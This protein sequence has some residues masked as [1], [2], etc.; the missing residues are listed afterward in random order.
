MSM[1]YRMP[2]PSE[3]EEQIEFIKYLVARDIKHTAIPNH[4][5]NPHRSQQAHNKKLGLNKGLCDVLVA[6]PGI[7]LAWVE[8]KRTRLSSTSPEQQAWVDTL[9]T[10]PGN[11]ARICKGWLKAVEFIEEL[12]PSSYGKALLADRSEF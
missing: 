1:T 6:L 10:C 9:N 4:T 8:M 12:S 7:G 11:E 5:Y 2:P 3:D